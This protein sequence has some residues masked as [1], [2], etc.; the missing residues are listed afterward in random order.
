MED[1]NGDEKNRHFQLMQFLTEFRKSTEDNNRATN[2]KI[3]MTNTKIDVKMR[4][5][6]DDMKELSTKIDENKRQADEV[7][8]KMDVRL[9]MLEIE[10]T[11]VEK[12]KERREGW[13][14]KVTAKPT[15]KEKVTGTGTTGGAAV[16]ARPSEQ[17]EMRRSI[18]QNE[19]TLEK[20]TRD[21]KT[22]KKFCRNVIDR[23]VLVNDTID[24]TTARTCDTVN[25]QKSDFSLLMG[26][27]SGG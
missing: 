17:K 23:S 4:E 11:K 7:T 25:G 14:E 5:I 22:Q 3:E 24:D 15:V 21:G 8:K 19:K 20:F 26:S 6:N 10:M 27:R 12:N 13:K 1:A 18:E 2:E 9:K 16:A